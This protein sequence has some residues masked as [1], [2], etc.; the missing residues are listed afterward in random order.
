LIFT[1]GYKNLDLS[2]VKNI[3]WA[4]TY[5]DFTKSF[6]DTINELDNIIIKRK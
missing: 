6:K 4:Q 3:T 2:K 5:W 1:D